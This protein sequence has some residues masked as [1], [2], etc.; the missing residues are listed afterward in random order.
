MEQPFAAVQPKAH[1][2][3]KTPEVNPSASQIHRLD[4]TGGPASDPV[5]RDGKQGTGRGSQQMRRPRQKAGSNGLMGAFSSFNYMKAQDSG[6]TAW[7]GNSLH[8]H[9][10]LEWQQRERQSVSA[11]DKAYGYVFTCDQAGVNSVENGA[12]HSVES[13]TLD[14]GSAHSERQDIPAVLHQASRHS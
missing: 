9:G 13:W 1:C 3:K 7:R 6:T 11:S 4:H 8:V 14:P 2:T 5:T 12:S 10:Q